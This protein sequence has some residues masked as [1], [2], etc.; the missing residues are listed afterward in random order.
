MVLIPGNESARKKAEQQNSRERSELMNH[1][2]L[3]FYD[4]LPPLVE[5]IPCVGI[6]SNSNG[7]L[8]NSKQANKLK[9]QLLLIIFDVVLFF[10]WR[11]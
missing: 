4:T 3:Y 6:K 9:V 11:P 1:F 7:K 8:I 5:Q 10:T 2:F